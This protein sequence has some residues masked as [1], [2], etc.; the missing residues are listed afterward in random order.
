MSHTLAPPFLSMRAQSSKSLPHQLVTRLLGT[1][2]FNC[3]PMGTTWLI[4]L[5]PLDKIITRSKDNKGEDESLASRMDSRLRGVYR[6]LQGWKSQN[7]K[8]S[9]RSEK[10]IVI[11]KS[12]I[13]IEIGFKSFWGTGQVLIFLYTGL[14]LCPNI[15]SI[16]RYRET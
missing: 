10:R 2:C 5:S 12:G 16:K 3:H 7:Q 11:S 6:F 4:N 14:P 8:R 13:S 15:P 9:G 1:R